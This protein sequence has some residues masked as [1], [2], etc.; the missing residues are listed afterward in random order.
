MGQ[1]LKNW[2]LR[3]HPVKLTLGKNGLSQRI[4]AEIEIKVKA[5]IKFKIKVRKPNQS[6]CHA[7]A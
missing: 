1:N 6:R 3:L 4:K 2:D 7:I 5:E